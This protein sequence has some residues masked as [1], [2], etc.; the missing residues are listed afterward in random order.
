MKKALFLVVAMLLVAGIAY[1]AT[2]VG[3]KHD[4]TT[5]SIP[6]MTENQVC[7]FCHTPHNASTTNNTPLWNHTTS[8][9]TYTMYTSTTLD[10]TTSGTIAGVSRACLSCHDGTV[11]VNSLANVLVDGLSLGTATLIQNL[12]GVNAAS[13]LG[14]DLSND[15]P[16]SISYNTVD[17]A[18][19]APTGNY[20]VSGGNRLPLFSGTGVLTVECASCHAVHDPANSPFLR[21]SNASSALCRVCHNK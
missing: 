9:A 7:I 18:L 16:I 8:T 10:G 11:A 3:S 14:T 5:R 4:M 13:F 12:P 15:H 21:M 19:N 1:G 20:V 17:T 2:I 6:G